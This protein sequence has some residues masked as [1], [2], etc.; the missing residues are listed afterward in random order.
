MGIKIVSILFEQAISA[1]ISK[2]LAR[3]QLNSEML[4]IVNLSINAETKNGELFKWA[5]LT[6][7][8]S[9]C[10]SGVPEVTLPGAIAMEFFALAADIF[11]DIQD[12]DNDD[13]PWRKL[14]NSN[15]L[16]IA[17][18]L[19]MI[20]YEAVSTIPYNEMKMKVN[21]ILNHT[22]LRASNGQFQEHI[23]DKNEEIT[24][25]QYFEIVKRKSGSLTACAC[26]IGAILGGASEEVLFQLEHFGTNL[27][28]MSQI[29]ND[30]NDFLNNEK[31]SDILENRKTLPYVYLLNIIKGKNRWFKELVQMQ[32]KGLNGFD[33]KER[34]YLKKLA[35]DEGAIH[36]CIV[37]HEMFR[38][39]SMEI[40]EA[41]PV[42][43]KHK[44]KMIKLV[45][46][47]II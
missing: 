26:K 24:F 38:Q 16:N 20:S 5:H 21:E 7:F 29:Q 42:L 34:E 9:E 11:D 40:I 10:V 32:T 13:L 8:S 25:E 23:N 45:E 27:G 47:S 41:I 12:Q 22:G 18:C 35:Y 19:L 2:I 1:E 6:L 3:A 44:E 4:R 43:E 33:N 30:L 15:A 39:K 37:M 17:I 28:I 46:K 36:Y 14:S 31:K